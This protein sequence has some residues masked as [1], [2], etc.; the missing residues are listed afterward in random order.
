MKGIILAGGL[1]T[2]L[3]PNTLA[4]S[5]QLIPIYDKPMIYY[6]LTT[7]MLAGIREILIISTP[8]HLPLYRKL[9]GD[10]SQWGIELDYVEQPE[11]K[12]LAQAF[13]LKPEFV[14]NDACAL[15]LGDNIFY[16]AGFSGLVQDAANLKKGASI[17]G[18]QVNSP[19][20]FGV[21]EIG[22]DG[23]AISIEEK[24]EHP[25]SNWAVTGLYF[26]DNQVLDIARDVKPSHRGEL[27]IT[28]INEAYMKQGNLNVVQL[29]RGTAW[30]DTGTVDAML[31]ASNF[32]QTVEARQG[33]KIA[34]PEEVSWR[35]GFI[36]PDELLRLGQGYKND[37]GTYLVNLIK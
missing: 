16:G 24:P 19:R 21:V 26:F 31:Q 3:H 15:A 17:F 9:L 30:L 33:F 22:E 6:P 8:H 4:I 28:C 13:L 11:P 18:Y 2:R 10:G 14:G 32:V 5:K 34:C 29:P 7:L 20:S 37:Y 12:G 36:S 25:K 27:E 23:N 35:Q 1:G